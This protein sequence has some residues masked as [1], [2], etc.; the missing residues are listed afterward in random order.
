MGQ[1]VSLNVMG[2]FEDPCSKLRGALDIKGVILKAGN[3]FI[4]ALHMQRRAEQAW[5]QL[6]AEYRFCYA[7]L[8]NY[9]F[10]KEFSK[11]FIIRKGNVLIK[12]IFRR[13]GKIH[14]IPIK[15]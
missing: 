1:P 13:S 8:R 5:I 14:A 15:P 3:Q 2:Y 11:Q 6:T 4:N 12:V 9:A 7:I 10:L